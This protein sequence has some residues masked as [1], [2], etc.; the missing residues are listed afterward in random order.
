[1]LT[2]RSDEMNGLGPDETRRTI[3]RGQRV[4]A[5]A[6][7]APARGFLAPAWQRGHVS[8]ARRPHLELDHVLGFFTLESRAGRKVPL[9]TW[10]WHC[11]RWRWLGNIGHAIGWLQ[12]PLNHRVPTLAIHPADLEG[13]FWPH[14][15]LVTRRLL[16]AGYEPSTLTGLLEH[17]ER[18]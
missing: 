13:G 10:S 15:L 1:M 11:G 17:V 9:A 5:A 7:G 16:E 4:F 14:I 3:D 18:S 12:Q 6:F 8:L 2:E